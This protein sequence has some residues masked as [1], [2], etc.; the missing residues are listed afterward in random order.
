[1]KYLHVIFVGFLTILAVFNEAQLIF[2][3]FQL[4]FIRAFNSMSINFK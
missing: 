4:I 2:I 3:R 1:M